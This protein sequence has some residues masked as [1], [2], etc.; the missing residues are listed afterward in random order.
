MIK[1]VG[2]RI[3]EHAGIGTEQRVYVYFRPAI[4]QW[5]RTKTVRIHYRGLK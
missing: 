4:Y 1:A 2:F 3:G 5:Y